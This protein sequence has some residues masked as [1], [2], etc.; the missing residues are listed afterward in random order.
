[1]THLCKLP[2]NPG[3]ILLV[4]SQLFYLLYKLP[5]RANGIF[6]SL[7]LYGLLYK[8]PNRSDG[9]FY[10]LALYGLFNCEISNRSDGL[11]YPLILDGSTICNQL[12]LGDN[13]RYE[14]YTRRLINILCRFDVQTS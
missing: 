3:G 1:M 12:G 6:Y 2:N 13:Y 11:F 8:L 7:V 4:L 14:I 10:L 5:K 9:I